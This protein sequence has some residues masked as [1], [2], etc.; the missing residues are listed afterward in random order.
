MLVVALLVVGYAAFG[1]YKDDFSRVLLIGDSIPREYFSEVEK[2]LAGKAYF[3]AADDL[4]I[5]LRSVIFR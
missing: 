4:Q 1:A 3:G 5:R 2:A